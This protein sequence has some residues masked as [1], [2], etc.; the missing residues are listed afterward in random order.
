MTKIIQSLVVCTILLSFSFLGQP[1]IT[2]LSDSESD[3]FAS[4][5]SH[6]SFVAT[7]NQ[8]DVAETC[9]ELIASCVFDVDNIV[10]A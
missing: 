7:S 5:Q 2:L 1:P 9:G 8:E 3:T 10:R 4:W 6:H